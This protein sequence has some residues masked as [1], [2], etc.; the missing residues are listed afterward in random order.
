M[1]RNIVNIKTQ[2]TNSNFIVYIDFDNGTFATH[3]KDMNTGKWYDSR[4]LT[5]NELNTAK[6]LAIKDGKWTNWKA[7]RPQSY[8]TVKQGNEDYEHPLTGKE[9]NDLEAINNRRSE[10]ERYG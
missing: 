4:T 8:S 1:D 6:K 7:P 3:S 2:R 5:A 9:I 10:D